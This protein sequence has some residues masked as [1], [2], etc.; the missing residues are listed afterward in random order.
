MTD[1]RLKEN[2]SLRGTLMSWVQSP[3]GLSE[4][5]ELA[6]AVRMALGTDRTALES[7]V[8]PDPDSTDRRGWWGDIDAEDIWGGWPIG[9]KNWLLLRAKIADTNSVE[10]S[11]VLRAEMYTREALQ[12]FIDK[13]IASAIDVQARRVGR[14]QIDVHVTIYRGPLQAIELRYALLWDQVV[15][16]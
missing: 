5:E 6:T 1:I 7:D 12:P 10:G 9:C 16:N 13:K 3:R 4:E 14:Q 11:T 8:L 2:L 15:S